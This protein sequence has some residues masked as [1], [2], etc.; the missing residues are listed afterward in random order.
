MQAMKGQKKKIQC[1]PKLLAPLINM[2]KND[3]IH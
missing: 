3:R 2:S 1:P